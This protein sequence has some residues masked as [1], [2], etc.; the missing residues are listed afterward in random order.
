MFY[1]GRRGTLYSMS[2]KKLWFRRKTYGWGWQPAT[3]QGWLAVAVFIA[4]VFLNFYRI[5]SASHSASDTLINF[6]PETFILSLALILVC[7]LT[8]EK[9]RWQWGKKSK[10]KAIIFDFQGPIVQFGDWRAFLEQRG[11]SKEQQIEWKEWILRYYEDAHAGKW[12][13]MEELLRIQRP[14]AGLDGETFLAIQKE[15]NDLRYVKPETVEWLKELKR[16]HALALLT[17]YT[18]DLGAVLAG[19]G[20]QSMF[21]A[22]VNSYDVKMTKPDPRMYALVL[23]KLGVT[24]EEAAFIDDNEKNVQVAEAL[25]IRSIKYGSFEQAKTELAALLRA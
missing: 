4:A 18:A 9:P 23:E 6:V 10:I 5:D 22:V 14:P 13:S 11:F 1:E 8:G 25:G 3:W 15:V 17:N 12:R 19:F 2:M 24:S 21:D 16:T 7:Y 20:L